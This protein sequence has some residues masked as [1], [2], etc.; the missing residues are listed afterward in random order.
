MLG[1]G[2]RWALILGAP[3]A[4]EEGPLGQTRRFAPPQHEGRESGRL[5]EPAE[6]D[7]FSIVLWTRPLRRA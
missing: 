3:L 6:I 5:F 1:A 7:Y 4:T 2:T